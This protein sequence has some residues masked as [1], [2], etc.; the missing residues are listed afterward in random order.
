M[1]IRYPLD[2]PNDVCFSQINIQLKNSSSKNTS[3]FSLEEQVYD[4]G[5]EIWEISGSLPLL[6]KEVGE[7]YASFILSLRGQVGTFL[8]P[9]SGSYQ[10]RGSWLG[11]PVVDGAS[12]T[13][14]ELNIKGLTPNQTE[15]AK[16]GDFISIGS[17]VGTRLYKIIADANSNAD[18]EMTVTI[19]PRLRTSPSDLATVNVNN[20]K[21]IFRLTEQTASYSVSLGKR[22][23]IS[24]NCREAL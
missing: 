3:P 6:K 2:F 15:V 10:P 4:F 14:D 1:T 7:K 19:V 13:G 16:A 21:G 9:I 20:A 17:G 23:N 5:S 22:Y 8:L 11:T 24:F 18:G 12:Q